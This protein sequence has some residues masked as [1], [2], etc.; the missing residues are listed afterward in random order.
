MV[1]WLATDPTGSGDED[2]LIIGDL[3]SYRN[4]DPIDAIEAG[5]DDTASTS[6]DYTDLLDALIGS[7]AYSYVFDGQLGYLDYALANAGLF[8]EVSGVTVWHI[9]A[10]EIPVFDYNDDI[11]DGSAEASFERESAALP[12]YEANAYRASDHDPVIIGL[13]VCDEI[14]PT[15]S[16]SLSPNTLWPPNHKYV[17]VTATVNANDNFDQNPTITLLGVTSNEP[18]SGLGN[19]DKPND[20]VIIDTYHV[21]LRAERAGNGNG[22]IYTFTYQVTDACGNSTTATA[23]VTVP[24]NQ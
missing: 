16:V 19:G 11:D 12:I 15:L 9:N 20:I 3:N 7:N 8:E 23:T 6:D 4:E 22:R 21:D 24:H 18:D 2:F 5:A 13:D 17:T 10:D 1:D 14:A